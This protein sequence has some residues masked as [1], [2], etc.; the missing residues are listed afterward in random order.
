MKRRLS[1]SIALVAAL[2]LLLTPLHSIESAV[3]ENPPRKILT[4]W[5]PYY[6]MKTYLPAVLTNADLISEIMPFW[7]TLK[8]N[9]N[10]KKASVRDVYSPANP[11]V[12]M[13][14]PLTALRA[15]NMKIIPTITDGTD[16]LVLANLLSKSASRKQV[17][18]VIVGAVESQNYDGIDLDFEG[19]AFIDPSSSWKATAPN[20]VLFIKE[21]SAVLHSKNKILS[22]S[23]PY[24]YNPAEAQ[25]GYFVYAW[26][27]IAPHIDRLRIMTYDYSVSRPGPI[28][29]ITWVEKTVK[30]AI[31]IM[32]PSKVFVGL[33]G[34]GKDWVTAVQGICPANLAAVIKP[35]ARAGAFL[36]RDGTSIAATYGAVPTYDSK[37]E[38][39]TFSYKREYTGTTSSGLSTTCTASR[40][41]W[42]QNAQS[43]SVRAQL[44]A[45]YKLGGL[46][47]WVIGQEEPLAMVAIRDVAK[48]IAP[49][50]LESSAL[51]SAPEVTYG[52]PITISG[53]ITL[54]DKTPVSDLAFE[55]VATYL[56]GTTRV[57]TTGTTGFDGKYSI[58]MLLG[59]AT[60]LQVITQPT[61]EREGSKTK[62]LSVKILRNL[63]ASPPTSVKAGS[64]FTISGFVLPRVA[65]V[66]VQL[67]NTAGKA[68][69]AVA[70]TDAQGAFS[71]NVGA[72]VKSI[73][74]YR[75]SINGDANWPPLLSSPFSIIYR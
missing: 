27:Q 13:V 47:Q 63:I 44:V 5:L 1:R 18:D 68:I 7:Y 30:Y 4:G 59:K 55:V 62:P 65:D 26:A 25:K 67:V 50:P 71:I 19:F 16:K 8:F 64:T 73:V 40:T 37:F 3:A 36:M 49:A 75:I 41:A 15:A 35:S 48:S 57:L 39:L 42:Y 46:A 28:G 21:L 53:L 32:P 34:Y 69:G 11:S 72:Q 22:V 54:K 24:L 38:E 10:T 60:S 66:E 51:L 20:W 17:I 31:S 23:T 29:P 43:F 52:N 74:A 58:P 12:P 56:D 33:P 61:W 45:K 70:L 9:A 6:S 14:E 2:I